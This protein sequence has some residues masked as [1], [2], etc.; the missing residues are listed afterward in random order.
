MQRNIVLGRR[1]QH[2]NALA[3]SRSRPRSTP[4]GFE[5]LSL[6]K[7]RRGSRWRSLVW[8]WLAI[9]SIPA[10]GGLVLEILG[11]PHDRTPDVHAPQRTAALS[12]GPERPLTASPRPIAP[13]ALT[14]PAAATT[15]AT[16]APTR[17]EPGPAPQPGPIP[18]AQ[19]PAITAQSDVPPRGRVL[20][21]LHPARSEGSEKIASRLAA[22]AGVDPGQ[23]DVGP[24]GVAKS[25]AV[26]RF[27]SEGDHA[28]ARRLGQELA[29]MGYTWKI[30]N[31]AA[32]SWAWK[33]QA[34][35]VFLPEK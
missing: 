9:L 11:P 26:I 34:I 15:P 33:D 8:F 22:Q 29:H 4:V 12:A 16:S 27:Y 31:F 24:I 10:L 25:R 32:R 14:A 7:Y 35:E 13:V 28:L 21:M 30:E 5:V 20:I 1:P 19:A 2:D 3:Q 17:S 23:I 6:A 18:D